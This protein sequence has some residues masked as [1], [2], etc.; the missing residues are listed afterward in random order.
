M[1]NIA[2]AIS[3]SLNQ[4]VATK[5]GLWLSRRGLS[6]E[7]EAPESL[8]VKNLELNF[9]TA[10]TIRMNRKS[11]LI[12]QKRALCEHGDK[13]MSLSNKIAFEIQDDELSDEGMIVVEQ[14][15]DVNHEG[16]DIIVKFKMRILLLFFSFFPPLSFQPSE[17]KESNAKN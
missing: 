11:R 13:K 16:E 9:L 7:E 14:S 1:P 4:I 10:K 8:L 6:M 5:R 3:G 17:I 12:A 2:V 15:R